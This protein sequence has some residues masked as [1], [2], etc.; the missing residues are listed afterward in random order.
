MT[1]LLLKDNDNK[2][3]Q[4]MRLITD[5]MNDLISTNVVEM[6]NS[7]MDIQIETVD[8]SIHEKEITKKGWVFDDGLY[9]KLLFRYTDKTDKLLT[10]WK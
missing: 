10:R 5:E 1:N 6:L 9:E 8:L 2:V 4:H 7:G 3:C